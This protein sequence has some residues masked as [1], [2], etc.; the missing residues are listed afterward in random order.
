MQ[1]VLLLGRIFY[2]LIF[3]WAFFGHFSAK[4]IEF[5]TNHGIPMATVLMPILGIIAFLGGLS[6]LL[7]YKAKWGAWL[8]VIF[9]AVMTCMMHKFWRLEDPMMAMVHRAMFLKNLALIGAALMI[10]FF[11]SGPL[12]LEKSAVKKGRK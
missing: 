4:T 7:G 12:S 5:A 6:I 10:A 1:Y 8:I 2:S 3:L 9:L 11:G